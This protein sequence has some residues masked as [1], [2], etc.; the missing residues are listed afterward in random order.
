MGFF[1]SLFGEDNSSKRSSGG[2][3][4]RNAI[5]RIIDEVDVDYRSYLSIP[6]SLLL[7][8][9]S[10]AKQNGSDRFALQVA[11]TIVLYAKMKYLHGSG[12]QGETMQRLIANVTR[13]SALKYRG[14]NEM[15]TDLHQYMADYMAAVRQEGGKMIVPYHLKTSAEEI[16]RS[17]L[18][19]AFPYMHCLS[20]VALGDDF[21]GDS[22]NFLRHFIGRAE[23]RFDTYKP[24]FDEYYRALKW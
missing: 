7:E 12:D 14:G 1:S 2:N 9:P 4:H 18:K 15:L 6:S 8:Y 19:I 13:F 11:L 3:V 23:R 21:T 20:M 10:L 16:L 24:L 22:A 17:G 5:D